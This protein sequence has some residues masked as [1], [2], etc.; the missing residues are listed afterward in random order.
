MQNLSLKLNMDAMEDTFFEDTAMLGIVT[1]APPYRLCWILNEFFDIDFAR[2]P[3]QNID[4]KRKGIEYRF[5]I[6]HYDLPNSTHK[7]LLYKLKQG[8][9]PLLPET[10][11]LDYLWLVQTGNAEA[12]AMWLVQQLRN[13]SDVQLATPLDPDQMK[14]IANLLI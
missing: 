12:D 1:A 3:E 14:S 8:S 10:R 2:D 5:P 7:Y 11:Q 13:I 4:L 9:E 6:Y